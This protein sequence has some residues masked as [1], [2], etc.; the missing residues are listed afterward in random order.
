V[1]VP[2]NLEQN[3]VAERKNR[4]IEES[5]KEMLHNQDLPKFQWGEETKTTVYI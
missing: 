1:I 2:F 5:V 4:S 3:G